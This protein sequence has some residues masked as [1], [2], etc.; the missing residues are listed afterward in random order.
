MIHISL[1]LKLA[2]RARCDGYR[3]GIQV[4][5]VSSLQQGWRRPIFRDIEVCYAF[6]AI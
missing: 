3:S 1:A 2:M 4:V 5:N 6:H